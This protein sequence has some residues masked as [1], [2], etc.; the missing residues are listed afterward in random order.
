MPKKAN[1]P[2]WSRRT[3]IEEKFNIDSEFYADGPKFEYEMFD[4]CEE[5]T[6]ISLL[7]D[8]KPEKVEDFDP[9]RPRYHWNSIPWA[10]PRGRKLPFGYKRDENNENILHPI[11]EELEA[12]EQAKI[13]LKKYSYGTV[14]KWLT[15]TTGRFIDYNSLWKRVR[16]DRKYDTKAIA[17]RKWAA[18]YKKAILAAEE[19]EQRTCGAGRGRPYTEEG[20]RTTKA[21][22]FPVSSQPRPHPNDFDDGTPVEEREIEDK[23]KC[24]SGPRRPRSTRKRASE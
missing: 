23:G 10:N 20:E 24:R 15:A 18:R 5:N 1:L 22:Y 19:I 8:A 6:E 13:Y 3:D 2:D 4:D 16:L 7:F 14:A 9:D 17:A 12:L 21:D 11:P